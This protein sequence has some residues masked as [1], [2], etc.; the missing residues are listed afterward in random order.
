MGI[1]VHLGIN[2]GP[3]LLM[4]ENYR[5]GLVWNLIRCRCA[6]L[7][8][9]LRRAGFSGGWLGAENLAAET[10]RECSHL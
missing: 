10:D 8:V 6:Y 9:G 3:M 2:Q 4:L 5:T 7:V 1:A